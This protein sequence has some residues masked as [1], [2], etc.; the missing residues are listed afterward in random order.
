M[1]E[2]LDAFGIINMNGRVYDPLTAMFFSPDPFVQAPENWLN[3]NRYAYCYGNP[4]KYTDPDGEIIFTLICVFVPGMQVFLPIAV[5]ADAAWMSEYAS[6]V[7]TNYTVSKEM[8]YTSNDIWFGKIDWFDVGYSAVA[9]G[10]S[11]AV[12]VAAPWIKYGS[13]LITNAVDLY[14][15]GDVKTIFGG[16]TKD[17]SDGTKNFG[18]YLANTVLEVGAI[19]ATDLVTNC[20]NKNPSSFPKDISRDTPKMDLLNKSGKKLLN[21]TTWDFVNSIM[22]KFSQEGLRLQYD[23]YQQQLQNNN[24]LPSPNYPNPYNPFYPDYYNKRDKTKSSFNK[25]MRNIFDLSLSTR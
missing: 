15:N 24:N 13:P 23:Q 16:E 8:N 10:V 6:Q 17:G 7:V 14:G 18:M 25:T 5:A 1:H 19:A 12:P 21:Q 11:V 4:F 22:S 20:L 3:F 9:G 2:H